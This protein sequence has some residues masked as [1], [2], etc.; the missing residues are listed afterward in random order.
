MPISRLQFEMGIDD[1]IEG[2]MV[3]VY[4]LL[5]SDP[6]A[7]YAEAEL[8]ERFAANTPGSYIDT[9]Y[10]DVALQKVVEIGAVEARSVANATYYAFSQAVD[11]ATWQLVGAE[12]EAEEAVSEGE[13]VD[14]E[15]DEATAEPPADSA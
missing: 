7:A 8:Y 11:K 15:A 12:D 5:E 13:T 9:S 3:A 4:D 14:S 2:L 6:D 10:L 1:H